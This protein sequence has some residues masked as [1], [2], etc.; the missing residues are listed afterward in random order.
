MI[1]AQKKRREATREA[2][3][4]SGIPIVGRSAIGCYV[5]IYPRGIPDCP[6]E[7]EWVPYEVQEKVD[8]MRSS[9]TARNRAHV[10]R[11][12]KVCICGAMIEAADGACVFCRPKEF[13]A[14]PSRPSTPSQRRGLRD[15]T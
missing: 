13:R 9:S 8:M 11:G 12:G 3:E 1:A 6:G 10:T 2:A 14:V 5:L 4:Q 7:Q 15:A